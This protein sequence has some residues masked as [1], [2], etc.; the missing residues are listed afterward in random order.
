MPPK[1]HDQQNLLMKCPPALPQLGDGTGRD[2]L[3]T[4]REWASQYHDCATRHNG[5]VDTLGTETD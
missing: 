5:L 2:V 3:V 1:V 4:M